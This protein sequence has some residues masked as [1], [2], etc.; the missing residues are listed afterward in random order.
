[1]RRDGDNVV[2]K[3]AKTPWYEGPA[4]LDFL[5]TVPVIEGLADL[6]GRFPVQYV[7]RPNLNFR[8]FA[9]QLAS[10]IFHQGEEVL[11]CRRGGVP[12]FRAS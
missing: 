6:P 11:A 12:A 2:E 3:S 7:L 10:G 5:E 9:G 4:L 1:M 8:G